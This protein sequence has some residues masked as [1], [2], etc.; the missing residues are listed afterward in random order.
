MPHEAGVEKTAPD[1]CRVAVRVMLNCRRR[2][3]LA[4][5]FT[6][7]KH[8]CELLNIDA[9]GNVQQE[10]IEGLNVPY[11]LRLVLDGEELIFMFNELPHQVELV[12][13][14]GWSLSLVDD[15]TPA[16][17]NRALA[18]VEQI[19]ASQTAGQF[20]AVQRILRHLLEHG[21]IGRWRR[22]QW[23]ADIHPDRSQSEGLRYGLR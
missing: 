21:L 20:S 17:T 16:Q 10:A 11:Q 5:C 2:N 4:E 14:T 8:G 1:C 19:T 3:E 22:S 18:R 12:V 9:G 15:F 7:D 23:G 13:G 6:P